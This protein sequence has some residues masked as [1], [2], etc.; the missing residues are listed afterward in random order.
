MLA[1]ILRNMLVYNRTSIDKP[2]RIRNLIYEVHEDCDVSRY[3]CFY[4]FFF[5]FS[6]R[7]RHTRFDCDWSSDVCS[8]DLS[9][10]CSDPRM[11][12]AFPPAHVSRLNGT[13][14]H[15]L[16]PQWPCS[17]WQPSVV[18]LFQGSQGDRKSVV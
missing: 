18:R 14:F 17:A 7:R 6:S 12:M 8:S 2:G 15:V 11:V 4:S 13:A 3:V 1:C 9:S 10:R 16:L 5:F